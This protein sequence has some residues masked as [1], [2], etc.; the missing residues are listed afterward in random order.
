MPNPA[1]GTPH[2]KDNLNDLVTTRLHQDFA[3]LYSDQTVGE[4]LTWVRA[5]PPQERI[6][7]FYVVDREGRLQGVVPTRRLI[8]SPPEKPLTDII[9]RQTLSLPANATVQDA[10]EFFIRHRLLAFPVLDEERRIIGVVDIDLYTDEMGRLRR[11]SPVDRWLR[12]LR[13]FLQIQSASGI[14]LLACAVIA[15]ILANS[16]WSAGFAEFWHTPVTLT[17]GGFE[18][19]ESL[20]HFIN[21]GLM[22]LFFFVVGLE[23]KREIVAGELSDRRKAMLPVVAA[24]GGMV[25]P[26]SLYLML[27]FGK[28]TVAG[29]GIPM[30]TDIAFLVGFLALLGSRVPPGLKILLLSLAIAD[31]I[32]AAL[33]IAVAYTANL[34]LPILAAGCAGFVLVL[35]LRK[36]GVRQIWVYVVLGIAICLAFLKSGVH[37]TVAGVG[38]GLLTPSR[39]WLG[40]RVPLDVLTDMFKRLGG[41][42]KG[43]TDH[44]RS[45]ALSPLERLEHALHPWVAFIIMPLF[46]LANAGV[47]LKLAALG[48][49]VAVAVAIGLVVGKPAGIMLFSWISVR[50]R[51]TRLPEEI[52]W[53]ILLGGGCLAGIGFT[54]SLF[55]AGLALQGVQLDEAKTGILFGSTVSGVLGFALLLYFLPRKSAQSP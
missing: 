19:H 50:T 36:I 3:H 32:G 42:G 55:I 33:V 40:D 4:A 24:L 9:D 1:G 18:L 53:R 25:V 47:D 20:L 51:L 17:I 54:M 44:D 49:P 34:S 48:T 46:A 2:M 7:Y 45:E 22:P 8:L 29:W 13:Q 5:H 6:I 12:P 39:P 11:Q 31:D 23:I 21:D 35:F 43:G 14:I 26:A 41:H 28:P 30:A 10:C 27:Q 38:L 16:P 15:L 37:P 52:N